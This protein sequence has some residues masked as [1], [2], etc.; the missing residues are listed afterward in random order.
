MRRRRPR[1]SNA[2]IGLVTVIGFTGKEALQSLPRRMLTS[3]SNEFA[4]T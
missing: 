1:R 2:F 4:V 3:P